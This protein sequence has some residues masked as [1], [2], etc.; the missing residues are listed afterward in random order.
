MSFSVKFSIQTIGTSPFLCGNRWYYKNSKTS[1]NHV[2]CLVSFTHYAGKTSLFFSIVNYI[3]DILIKFRPLWCSHG[4]WIKNIRRWSTTQ[5]DY[6]GLWCD[7]YN[8]QLP[9]W[10]EFYPI[11][12]IITSYELNCGYLYFIA[13]LVAHFWNSILFPRK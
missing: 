13:K 9:S 6:P 8:L 2:S 5:R 11:E 1:Q 3:Q 7:R 10:D 12:R 4:P